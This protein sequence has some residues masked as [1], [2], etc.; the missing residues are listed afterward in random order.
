MFQTKQNNRKILTF[1]VCDT[2]K[3]DNKK[4]EMHENVI[5]L[6]KCNLSS[7]ANLYKYWY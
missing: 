1:T 5:Y 6:L 4:E 3:Y 7:F 2:I